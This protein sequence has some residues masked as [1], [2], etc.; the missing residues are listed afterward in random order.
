MIKSE[1]ILEDLNNLPNIKLKEI[2]YFNY[3]A[4]SYHKL[5]PDYNFNCF[6]G[7]NGTGKSTTLETLQ[8]I[9]TRFNGK[10]EDQIETYL[11]KSI[12]RDCDNF[13]I[14]AKFECNMGDYE[15]EIDK[16]GFIKDHPE[17]IKNFLY[18]LCYLSGFDKEL[19][20]FNLVKDRWEDFKALFESIT[21]YETYLEETMF[22]MGE[23]DRYILG[24]WVK[25]Q[26]ETIYYTECSAGERKVIKSISTLLNMEFTPRLI[27]IDN[28]E[29]HVE[30]NKHIAL[31]EGLQKTFPNS[32][33]FVTTHSARISRYLYNTNKLIDLREVQF[34]LKK[35]IFFLIDELSDL[36]SKVL[37]INELELETKNSL[38]EGL[39]YLK[40]ALLSEKKNNSV[41]MSKVKEL[42]SEING[43]FLDFIALQ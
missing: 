41:M 27:L 3:K 33:F 29:M 25:K 1:D 4:F 10:T 35:E 38:L 13:L 22:D 21:G 20:Q 19:N 28:I 32:Q 36:E 39:K 24:F 12:R 23:A 15:I 9:F 34:N 26:N 31:V 40:D 5:K 2:E 8:L 43:L 30:P 42:S 17:G 11:K 37:S 16:T 6:I 7:S 14:K 18:R